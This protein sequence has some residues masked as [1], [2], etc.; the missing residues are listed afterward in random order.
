MKQRASSRQIGGAHYKNMAIQ[1]AEFIQRNRLGWC[2]GNAVKYV[3]RHRNK[4]GAKD[5]R[6]A[7]HYLQ[8]LIE[9][10]YPGR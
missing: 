8:L 1:P 7:I 3:C 5:L 2:E 6:K 9:I 4:N 10:E